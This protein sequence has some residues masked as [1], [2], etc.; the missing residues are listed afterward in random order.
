MKLQQVKA[1]NIAKAVGFDQAA[2]TVLETQAAEGVGTSG[3]QIQTG[4]GSPKEGNQPEPKVPR[5]QP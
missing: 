2:I 4:T 1:R 3:S 5:P